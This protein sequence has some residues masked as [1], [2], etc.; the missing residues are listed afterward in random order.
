MGG[1]VIGLSSWLGDALPSAKEE[2]KRD[3]TIEE[4]ANRRY[5]EE[6]KRSS[7]AMESLDALEPMDR[8]LRLDTN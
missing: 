4:F 2:C 7:G 1:S 6:I 3:S 8:R 5:V